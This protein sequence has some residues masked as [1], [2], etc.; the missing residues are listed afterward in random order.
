MAAATGLD[1]STF[2]KRTGLDLRKVP[3]QPS[4][5]RCQSGTRRPE[6]LF[7]PRPAKQPR[8]LQPALAAAGSDQALE[9]LEDA[10]FAKTTRFARDARWNTWCTLASAWRLEPLPVTKELVHAIGASLKAGR[11]KSADQ[12]YT[13]AVQEHTDRVGQRPSHDVL[14]AITDAT[15]SIRRAAAAT[16]RKA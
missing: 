16:A 10:K 12:Y 11:H 6:E 9:A 8:G 3:T 14:L 1:C 4:P 15:R 2:C 5:A 7:P 13:R